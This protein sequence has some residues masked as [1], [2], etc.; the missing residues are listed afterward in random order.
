MAKAGT[1]GKLFGSL[2][3]I[4]IA[5]ACT[6]AGVPV[7]RSEVRLPDGPLRLLGEHEIEIHLHT[8][9]TV[10][11]R[12]EVI[13]DETTENFI[14]TEDAP[15]NNAGGDANENRGAAEAGQ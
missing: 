11:V 1:E 6:D 10:N 12:A 13:A 4:D 5:Q 2:G 15:A 9:V 3:T 14:D 8:G 7:E